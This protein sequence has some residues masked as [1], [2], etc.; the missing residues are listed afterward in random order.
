MKDYTDKHAAIRHYSALRF[1]M[2][3][4]FVAITA[5]ILNAYFSSDTTAKDVT[6]SVPLL[7]YPVHLINI[8]GVWVSIV[9]LTFEIALNFYLGGLWSQVP[10]ISPKP[11]Y[12]RWYI[13]WPVRVAAL[14]LPT[15]AIMMWFAI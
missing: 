6:V 8:I 9:F 7:S 11:I 13:V 5:I 2:L 12:R 15:V 10:S 1:A 3:T 14:S 4:V